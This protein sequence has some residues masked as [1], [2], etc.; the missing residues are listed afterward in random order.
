[1][2]IEHKVYISATIRNDSAA[3][4]RVNAVPIDL[5]THAVETGGCTFGN[6]KCWHT[7]TDCITVIGCCTVTLVPF[8]AYL[9]SII[10][11]DFA[12][13]GRCTI[14]VDGVFELT[15][16]VP[17]D[18]YISTHPSTCIVECWLYSGTCLSRED[19]NQSVV[20]VNLAVGRC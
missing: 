19:T 13:F 5:I 14:V 7:T 15:V 12:T 10:A 9:H 4:G 3:S 16:V 11:D 20:G 18:I 8:V 2:Y 17:I 1:M 6:C